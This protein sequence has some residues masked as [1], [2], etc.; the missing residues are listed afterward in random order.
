VSETT[1]AGMAMDSF[2]SLKINAR[3][4]LVLF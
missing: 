4:F 2:L 1:E 3:H